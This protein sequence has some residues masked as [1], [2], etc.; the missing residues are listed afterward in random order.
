MIVPAEF[1]TTN[2]TGLG[3]GQGKVEGRV[4]RECFTA[5]GGRLSG[6]RLPLS[7]SIFAIHS[8]NYEYKV[9]WKMENFVGRSVWP[10]LTD[11][12]SPP[13]ALLLSNV[14]DNVTDNANC[15]GWTV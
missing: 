14:N 3:R 9:F 7:I 1:F 13:F 5:A 8:H 4:A 11:F 6:F 12:T 10:S 2:Y 15:T